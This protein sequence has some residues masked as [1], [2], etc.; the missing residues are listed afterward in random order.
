[1]Q[2]KR[3][4]K[5]KSGTAGHTKFKMTQA[6][7]KRNGMKG[8]RLYNNEAYNTGSS[9]RGLKGKNRLYNNEVFNTGSARFGNKGAKALFNNQAYNT[10]PNRIT[11]AQVKKM[12]SG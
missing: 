4:E 9:R 10:G 11:D 6:Q 7:L 8:G 2:K 3:K 12:L 1:M 5:V